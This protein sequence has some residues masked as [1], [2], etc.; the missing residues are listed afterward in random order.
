MGREEVRLIAL[1]LD[2]TALTSDKTITQRTRDAIA[3]A[4]RQG[5][6]IVAT[7]GRSRNGIMQII[8]DLPGMHYMIASNG[9]SALDLVHDKL[10]YGAYIE[11]ERALGILEKLLTLGIM[12]D[13]YFDGGALSDFRTYKYIAQEKNGFPKWFIEYFISNRKPVENLL[14]M[15]RAG[16]IP[17]VEKVTV[18]FDDMS[19]RAKA[20]ELMRDETGLSIVA[21]SPF[22]M[23]I[24]QEDATKGK[25]LSAL[26]KALGIDMKNVM[27]IG[28][29]GNDVSMIKAAGLGVAMG[30]ADEQIRSIA[31]VLT[32]T[33]D[34]D[35]VALAIEKY[36]LI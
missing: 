25:A 20:F 36:A 21:G 17:V 6:E 22:N 26:A 31:D 35:G 11:P 3:K 30:N 18:S 4:G 5:I 7:S 9:A 24:S 14:G 13:I 23:E 1:D 34:E 19:L 8:A 33:N 29:T 16:K 2:G 32:A 28:D 27:A 12:G 10:I 15:L